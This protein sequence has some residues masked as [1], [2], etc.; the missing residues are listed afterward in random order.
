MPQAFVWLGAMAIALLLVE[1]L[2]LARDRHDRLQPLR[3]QTLRLE[4]EHEVHEVRS[5]PRGFLVVEL[6]EHAGARLA[7]YQSFPERTLLRW[8]EPLASSGRARLVL[9][10][11]GLPEGQY[12]LCE[13]DA[14]ESAGPREMDLPQESLRVLG[15]FELSR[16]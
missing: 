13:A 3:A 9:P 7:L 15:R 11:E 14:D 4:T 12:L 8:L 16:N 6:G 1:G 5:G 10:L 2:R